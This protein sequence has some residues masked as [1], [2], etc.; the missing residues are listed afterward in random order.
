MPSLVVRIREARLSTWCALASSR[1]FRGLSTPSHVYPRH[2]VITTSLFNQSPSILSRPVFW[3]AVPTAA[4]WQTRDSVP[5]TACV[6]GQ[7]GGSNKVRIG[8]AWIAT[9][10]NRTVAQVFCVGLTDG[11]GYGIMRRK[12]NNDKNNGSWG[13]ACLFVAPDSFPHK[14]S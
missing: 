5:C 10:N 6:V 12:D 14:Y 3:R 2:Y 9:H 13:R 11:S 7:P 1:H 4:R 8:H